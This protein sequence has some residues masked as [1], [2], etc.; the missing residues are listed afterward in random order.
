MIVVKEMKN[1]KDITK[2]IAE[3]VT[4]DFYCEYVRDLKNPREAS[5]NE[6]MNVFK[7]ILKRY[8]YEIDVNDRNYIHINND[9]DYELK[10]F[11]FPLID[12]FYIS[13]TTD[14]TKE[15]NETVEALIKNNICIGYWSVNDGCSQLLSRED[16]NQF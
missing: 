1:V 6:G 5:F 16:E 9:E 12:D 3:K 11:D 15:D 2:E 8:G 7:K 10:S 4:D 14:S 13:Y